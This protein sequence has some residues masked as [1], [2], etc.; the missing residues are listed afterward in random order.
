MGRLRWKR[1]RF[2]LEFTMK[3]KTRYILLALIILVAAFLRLYQLGAVP[4]SPDWDEVALGYNGY[5]ILHTGKDEYGKVFPVVLQSF[6]DYKP[7]LYTYLT[8]PPIAVFGLNVFATRLPSAIFGIMTVL[9]VYF[10]VKELFDD[11]YLALLSALLLAISPWHLQ[12]SRTA[13]ETNVGLAFNVF[14]ALFFI[15]GLKKPW[16]LSLAALCSA[17]SIYA[18][19]SEKVFTPL[20]VITLTLIYLRPLVK[21]PRKYL[22]AAVICGALAIAPMIFFIATNKHALVRAQATMAFANQFVFLQNDVQR[23]EVD[24]AHHDVLGLIFDNRRVVYLMTGISGYLTH[25]NLNWLFITGDINRHHAPGM[26]LLYLWELPFLFIGMYQF[27][28]NRKKLFA[29]KSGR[30]LFVAWFLLAPVP[31]AFTSELPHAVRTLNFLPTFQV[32][33]AAGIL[34][35]FFFVKG[36]QLFKNKYKYITFSLV[37]LSSLFIAFNIVYYLN[38]YFV[39]Q[40]YFY[41]Q[42]WQYGYQ[43]EVAMVKQLAP[44]YDKIIVSDKQPL[45]KSYMFHLF[46]LQYPPKQYQQERKSGSGNFASHQAFGKYS[47][48][49]IEWSKEKRSPSVLYVG[50]PQD[51]G[52]DAHVLKTIYYPNGEP[53]IKIVQG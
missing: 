17:L 16:L 4:L 2:S 36:R 51:F 5:S 37:A 30:I 32:F 40:N 49:P 10:L 11:D 50:S 19:Q 31:A 26:G 3:K 43:E 24:M 39:Q 35:V 33:I 44:D 46:Y 34:T 7:A 29:Q 1:I 38:Q 28:F 25:Y 14:T 52:S 53:A 9:A 18:Y 12:F 27:I 8:I 22:A 15:K 6:D 42:D 48:R 47:F 45:D 20:L 41:A 21:L 23:L 13:F